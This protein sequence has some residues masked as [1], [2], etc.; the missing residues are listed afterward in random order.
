MYRIILLAIILCSVSVS[1]LAKQQVIGTYYIPGLVESRKDGLFI[2]LHHEIVKRAG[3]DTEL[4]MRPTKRIQRSFKNDRLLAYF[5]ELWENVPKPASDVVVSETIWYKKII[6]YSLADPSRLDMTDLEKLNLGAVR[7]YSYG[8][9]LMGNQK[10]HIDYAD[11]DVLNVKRLLR[12]RVDVLL[13][14]SASTLSA[15]QGHV[16]GKEIRYD[17]SRPFAKLDVFYLCQNTQ[18]G[19]NLCQRLS[20][21]IRSVKADGLLTLDPVTGDSKIHLNS[22]HWTVP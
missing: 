2:R 14:D 7:G 1:S 3:L 18:D 4:I 5:P 17:L 15:V 19:I 13:G 21:A 6:L 20:E 12:G 22:P 16:R 10:L 11:N 8:Q 9:E